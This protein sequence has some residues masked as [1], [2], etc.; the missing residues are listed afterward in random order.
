MIIIS[1]TE[2][3]FKR[4]DKEGKV[5]ELK[6]TPEQIFEF[7]EQMRKIREEYVVKSNNSWLKAKDVWLD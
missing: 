3:I 5:K 2:K 6:M 1:E 4:L 7:F